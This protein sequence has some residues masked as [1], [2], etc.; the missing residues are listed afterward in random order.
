MSS[1]L[2]ALK[3]LE[4]EK[5][6]P[7]SPEIAP[8]ADVDYSSNTL[9]ADLVNGP[10]TSRNTAPILWVLGGGMFTVLVIGVVVLVVMLLLQQN[11]STSNQYANPAPVATTA[12]PSEPITTPVVAV[13]A[14]VDGQATDLD[15]TGST[16]TDEVVTTPVSL[17]KM[18]ATAPESAKAHSTTPPAVA[19][20]APAPQEA[21]PPAPVA[22]AA[23]AQAKEV[24]VNNEP[25]PPDIRSLPMLSRQD[26]GQYRLEGIQLN[27]LNE[28][29]PTRP[30]GNAF[31]NLEKVFIG[32]FLPGSNAKLIDVKSFG[33]AVEIQSTGQRFYIPR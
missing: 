26:R 20:P 25:L 2:E 9:L 13:A 3:K 33:V 15:D 30:I 5:Y 23:P 22:Y 14:E 32:E 28:Q 4:A 8:A 6:A 12:T 29:G 10:G 21:R 17:P 27:M 1:I 7:Q 11:Q 18:A 19:I 31:I 24:K 16:A